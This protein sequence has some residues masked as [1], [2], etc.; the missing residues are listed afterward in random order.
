MTVDDDDRIRGHRDRCAASG[1]LL[2]R[3]I[4][5]SRSEGAGVPHR[6]VGGRRP[7]RR[8]ARPSSRSPQHHRT[9][10]HRTEHRRRHHRGVRRRIETGVPLETR[11][12]DP[13]RGRQGAELGPASG[14]L[15]SP[16]HVVRRWRL[17]RGHGPRPSFSDTVHRPHRPFASPDHR[18]RP[19]PG[20]RL[21][22]QRRGRAPERAAEPIPYPPW[23]RGRHPRGRHL[24]HPTRFWQASTSSS[25]PC[26][27]AEDARRADDPPHGHGRRQPQRRHPRPLHRPTDRRHAASAVTVRRRD[28]LARPAPGSGPPSRSTAARN[29]RIRPT[30]CSSSPARLGLRVVSI[31]TDAHAPG[32]MEWQ[33]SGCDKASAT[34]STT[35]RS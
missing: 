3:P 35:P 19:V 20:E 1:D 18:P 9:R 28:R 17:D 21:D 5:R 2:P 33:I 24:D 27:Q 32:Q 4:A 11:G 10:R 25:P 29:A 6:P 8:R 23:C 26:T 7:R 14:R 15:P 22:E 13:P 12:V 16:Q 30:N 34:G 31:D